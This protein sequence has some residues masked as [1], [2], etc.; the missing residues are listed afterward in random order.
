MNMESQHKQKELHKESI[1]NQVKELRASS[2]AWV[3]RTA[4]SQ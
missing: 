1:L 4:G 2:M 3:V